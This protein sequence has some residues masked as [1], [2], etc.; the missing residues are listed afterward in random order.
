MAVSLE[1]TFAAYLAIL[2]GKLA[3]GLQPALDSGGR[4]VVRGAV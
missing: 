1:V 4:I 2:L 3:A